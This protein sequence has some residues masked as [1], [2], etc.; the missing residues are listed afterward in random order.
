MVPETIGAGSVTTGADD[1]APRDGRGPSASR[2]GALV[3]PALA[4]AASSAVTAMMTE[5]LEARRTK[6]GEIDM[7]KSSPNRF[8]FWLTRDALLCP[9]S[10]RTGG[11]VV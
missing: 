1:G 5:A 9:L 7:E 4:Q 3:A 2:V 11:R 6:A 8:P 10:S